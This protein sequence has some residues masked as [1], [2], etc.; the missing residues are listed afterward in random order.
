MYYKTLNPNILTVKEV[1]Y[2]IRIC[3]NKFI[4]ADINLLLN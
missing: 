1:K 3:T 4:I 2:N